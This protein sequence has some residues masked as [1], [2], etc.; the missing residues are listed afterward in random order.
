MIV[1]KLRSS[2]RVD[3]FHVES[4][5]IKPRSV[6]SS[7]FRSNQIHLR[8]DGKILI[9]LIQSRPVSPNLL[10]SRLGPSDLVNSHQSNLFLGAKLWQ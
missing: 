8:K 1:D 2:A 7:Q 3:S 6:F 9:A 4:A 10:L 5:R